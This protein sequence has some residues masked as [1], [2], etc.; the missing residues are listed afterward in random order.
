MKKY[1]II[2]ILILSMIPSSSHSSPFV[3]GGL[4]TVEVKQSLIQAGRWK[5]TP[6]VVVCQYSPATRDQ[7]NSAISWWS[8]RGY[9]FHRTIF[10]G[11]RREH[12]I[13]NSPNP[14]GYILIKLVTQD[15]LERLENNLAVTH[16]YVDNDTNEVSW[17]KIY[18]TSHIE[19]RVIEHEMGHS[20]G[21]MHTT[22]FG[23]LMN[24]KWI[25]GGWKDTGLHR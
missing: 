25:R 10:P 14:V 18:L 7:V 19:N 20:L 4:Q 24:S 15:V 17:A 11:D 3:L 13:C 2:A 8:S 23:H 21:W 9:S 12:S 6:T 22:E 1:L 16:F 5:M